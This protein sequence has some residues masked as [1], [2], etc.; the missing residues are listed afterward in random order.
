MIEE[1]KLLLPLIENVTNGA[2]WVVM[3]Y[4]TLSF[5][6]FSIGIA[7]IIFIA[8]KLVDVITKLASQDLDDICIDSNTKQKVISFLKRNATTGNSKYIHTRDVVELEKKL[9]ND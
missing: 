3:G 1:L 7:A 9:S 8:I 5:L 4:F 6:K 2:L